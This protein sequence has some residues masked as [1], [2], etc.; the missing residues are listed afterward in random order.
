[1]EIFLL[2]EFRFSSDAR[3]LFRMRMMRRAKSDNDDG[4]VVVVN[5]LQSLWLCS[6]SRFVNKQGIIFGFCYFIVLHSIGEE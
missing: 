6:P 4:I 1:M 2:T 5:L 3:E